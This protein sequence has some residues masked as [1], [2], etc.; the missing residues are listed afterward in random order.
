MTPLEAAR[1]IV[2]ADK[3]TVVARIVDLG[4]ALG[5]P[6]N[7]GMAASIFTRYGHGAR[8]VQAL[9]MALTATGDPW[10]FAM[11]VLRD[12]NQGKRGTP[13]RSTGTASLEQL[14]AGEAEW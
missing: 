4:D 8:V 14:R 2:A 7:G 11:G 13:R 6:R 5:Y 9:G 3:S 1:A 12:G 10:E